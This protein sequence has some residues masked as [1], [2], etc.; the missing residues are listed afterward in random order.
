MIHKHIQNT[1]LYTLHTGPVVFYTHILLHWYCCNG[2]VLCVMCVIQR[3][4]VWCW[5]WHN[6]LIPRFWLVNSCVLFCAIKHILL[7]FKVD[8]G[9]Y[10]QQKEAVKYIYFTNVALMQFFLALIVV[11]CAKRFMKAVRYLRL[12]LY[13]E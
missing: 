13:S 8:H 6:V 2:C 12:V 3:W 1:I 4:D 10:F 7:L 9:L 11:F 5:K